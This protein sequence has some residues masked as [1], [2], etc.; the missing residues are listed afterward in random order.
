MASR[1]LKV[2]RTAI[3]FHDA[4]V[5]APSQKAALAA[6]GSDRNLFA[7]GGAEPVED[8]PL[9]EK[10]LATPGKV[11]KVARGTA[12]QHLAALPKATKKTTKAAPREKIR[13]A[14]AP[15][16]APDPKRPPRPS[17][18]AVERAEKNVREAEKARV[19]DL[20]RIDRQIAT[21][22][23]ER[24]ATRDRHDETLARAQEKLAASQDDYDRRLAKW[25]DQ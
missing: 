8:G 10:A 18:T 25:S 15:K 21:L 13:K 23:A 19:A 16:K 3:G 11:I 24:R 17:R 12:D 7:I 5:A 14:P 9:A 6:W 4:Y 1:K 22:T 20:D 2:F